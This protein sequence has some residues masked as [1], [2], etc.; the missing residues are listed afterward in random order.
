M[1]KIINFIHKFQHCH[2]QLREYSIFLQPVN[3]GTQPQSI[4]IIKC[5]KKN[6]SRAKILSSTCHKNC[7]N[8]SFNFDWCQLLQKS[9]FWHQIK[10]MNKP[11]SPRNSQQIYS[12][13]IDDVHRKGECARPT[14]DSQQ[15]YSM[16]I[17]D[18]HRKG[19]CAR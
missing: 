17:D 19:E 2:L 4:F 12:M 15:I 10:C 6:G 8:P 1:S 11:Q 9:I 7:N 13:F 16:F 5:Q 14:H 3:C 18:V